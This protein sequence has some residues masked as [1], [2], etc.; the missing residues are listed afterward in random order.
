MAAQR[1]IAIDMGRRRLS[2][3]EADV[4]R[5]SMTVRR[6]LVEPL[7]DDLDPD[8]RQAIGAWVGRT[9]RAAGL[10]KVRATVAISREHVVLKRLTL[11]STERHELPEM[12]RLAL[13]RQLP[14]DPAGAVIDFACVDRTATSTTVIAV[15]APETVLASVRDAARTAGL[16]VER[17]S[18][19]TMGTAALIATSVTEG[20]PT[21]VLAVDI[22]GDRVEFT[23]IVGGVIKFSR[24]G[25]LPA[26]DDPQA[27]AD[28]VLTEARRTWMSY[29]IIDDS[30]DVKRAVVFGDQCVCDLVTVS[31][32]EALNIETET[33]LQH[34]RVDT[35]HADVDMGP[36]WPLAGLLLAPMLDRDVIDFLH[37][38]KTP[39]I[40]GRR[41]KIIY[42][43][44]AAMIILV[45]SGITWARFDLADHRERM[46]SLQAQKRMLL[47]GYLRY[48][49]DRYKLA[50]LEHW[51]SVDA[52]WLEHL[53]YIVSMTP[54]AD[55]VV[56]D[57]WTG[58]L[59][60]GGVKFDKKTRRFSS[61]KEIRIV[62]AG[63]AADRM[64]AD[65]F[66]GL[67]VDTASYDI[68][69]TGAD[70]RSGRR[71]LAW[72]FQYNLRTTDAVPASGDAPVGPE[73]SSP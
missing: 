11:P 9:L 42:G 35:S 39:D 20:P 63:E 71:R 66:R 44:A 29:R 6:V 24:A 28:A 62:V 2:V 16:N 4:D 1:A 38:H 31:L 64:T 22:S 46:D 50:H 41:R 27:I 34:V 43:I 73:H 32:R 37:P 52:D 59:A 49:R 53:G 51:E 17:M 8:D 7:P 23:V 48:G 69:T 25:E 56:L 21:S 58:T 10:G 26:G 67:L 3:I 61:P 68:S 5:G 33:F 30:E 54:P 70:A 14:F 57:S 60:F 40:A 45:F 13:Q 65:A 36:V 19:R 72:S 12:T 18:L 15:A 55:S 47:P